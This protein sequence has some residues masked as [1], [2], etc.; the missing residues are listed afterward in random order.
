M[1]RSASEPGQRKPYR[2]LPTV[3]SPDAWQKGWVA[4][5]LTSAGPRYTMRKAGMQTETT[6]R[7]AQGGS[8]RDRNTWIQSV[9][10]AKTWV[11]GPGQYK[12]ERE[13]LYD[14]KDEMDTNL[15]IQEAAAEYS[16][17]QEVKE[18]QTQVKDTPMRRNNG[19]YPK[20][21]PQF[22]PGPGS[23]TAFSTFGSASG[24]HRQAYFGGTAKN[25]WEG[26]GRMK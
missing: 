11:P 19:T 25:N 22:T 17:P 6:I 12:T 24:G 5:P 13:F 10:Q 23:Y 15:T 8:C 18:T 2:R 7:A 4:H 14:K 21:D 1:N 9:V 3:H 26:V 16:F 20:F